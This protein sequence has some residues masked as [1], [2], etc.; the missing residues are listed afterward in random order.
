MKRRGSL[1]TTATRIGGFL[2]GE[3]FMVSPEHL[4]HNPSG[5]SY[6]VMLLILPAIRVIVANDEPWQK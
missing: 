3:G 2:V 6:K 1:S 5:R 4:E